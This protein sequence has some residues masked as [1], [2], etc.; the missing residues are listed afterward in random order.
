MA[1]R[2]GID[3]LSEKLHRGEE[4][5]ERRPW[6][7]PVLTNH[8]FYAPVSDDAQRIRVEATDRFG[9][10]YSAVL[11]DNRMEERKSR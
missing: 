1:R 11:D 3:P 8:L 6:V 7:E 9:R 5:P 10:T 4:K 2:T